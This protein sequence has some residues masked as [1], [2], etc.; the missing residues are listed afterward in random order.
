VRRSGFLLWV[1]ASAAGVAAGFGLWVRR[2]LALARIAAFPCDD[3]A[4]DFLAA[5]AAYGT[6]FLVAAGTKRR[7]L[8]VRGLAVRSPPLDQIPAKAG[9]QPLTTHGRSAGANTANWR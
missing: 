1:L 4:P 5:A 3:T 6:C 8:A 7:G 2:R 9:R